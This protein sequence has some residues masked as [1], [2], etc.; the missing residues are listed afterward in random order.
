MDI[1]IK[2]QNYIYVHQ[3][4]IKQYLRFIILKHIKSIN[5][6]FNYIV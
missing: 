1:T 2:T 3:I 5:N 4:L 6:L